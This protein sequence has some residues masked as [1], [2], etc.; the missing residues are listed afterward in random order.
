[1]LQEHFETRDPQT[2]ESSLT[3]CFEANGTTY[4]IPWPLADGVD[5]PPYQPIIG[6]QLAF[7]QDPRITVLLSS[8]TGGGG[9]T[10]LN[11][12]PTDPNPDPY[13]NIFAL[14]DQYL[15]P[16]Y[17]DY[18]AGTIAH[19]LGHRIGYTHKP[20]HDDDTSPLVVAMGH[21]FEDA[22]GA[23]PAPAPAPPEFTFEVPNSGHGGE[24]PDKIVS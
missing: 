22:A 13:R 2:W 3:D 14:N 20:E 18:I 11:E 8:A 16:S 19:E 17:V 1:M 9:S 6:Y 24:A 10:F 4:T 5:L 7:Q 15:S 23:S 21:C 12:F